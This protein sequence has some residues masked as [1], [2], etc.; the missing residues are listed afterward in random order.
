MD[1]YLRIAALRRLGADTV[2]IKLWDCDEASAL[3]RVLA[4]AQGHPWAA[5]EEARMIRTLM[6]QFEKSQSAI[7][8]GAGRDVSWVNR[9][10]SL[11]QSVSDD[12]LASICKGHLS[13]D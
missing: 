13:T 2:C 5:I 9:R 6:Q 8:R 12:V 11:I 10:L 7:A 4:G 1:G 3:L